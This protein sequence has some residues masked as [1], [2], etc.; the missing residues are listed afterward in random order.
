MG[1]DGVLLDGDV[2][3]DRRHQFVLGDQRALR[4]G[5]HRQNGQRL[6][7]DRDWR[8]ANPEAGETAAA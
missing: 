1:L 4:L 7:L 8:A 2:R 6:A 3:P 5:Q